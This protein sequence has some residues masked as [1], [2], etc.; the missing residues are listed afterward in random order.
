MRREL[1]FSVLLFCWAVAGQED[2]ETDEKRC[3][4]DVDCCP[5]NSACRYLCRCPP[6]P[7]ELSTAATRQPARLLA[8]VI[9][10]GTMLGVEQRAAAVS[11]MFAFCGT[12]VAGIA[13]ARYCRD[14]SG[15]CRQAF[16]STP[17]QPPKRNY[18]KVLYTGN[19]TKTPAG[20]TSNNVH[21]IPSPSRA[22]SPSPSPAST[23]APAPAPVPAE[24]CPKD[25]LALCVADCNP[26]NAY[27]ACLSNCVE[28]CG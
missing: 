24:P 19:Y 14:K 3:T 23:P 6:E 5:P 1:L 9:A 17:P 11:C 18:S 4:V 16:S 25:T 2:V 8:G 10:C 12:G 26:A 28:L 7:A 21:D 13:K 20:N 15:F 27:S 22:L